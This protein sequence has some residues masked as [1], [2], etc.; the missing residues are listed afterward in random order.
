MSI[1]NRNRSSKTRRFALF[2]EET[3]SNLQKTSHGSIG[4]DAGDLDDL[5]SLHDLGH[6]K[7]G[8]LVWTARYNL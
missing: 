2:F 4:L 8:E 7:C 3:S 5:F 1:H 6:D